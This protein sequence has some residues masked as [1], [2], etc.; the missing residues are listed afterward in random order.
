MKRKVNTFMLTGGIF[1]LFVGS[2]SLAITK[3]PDW[4]YPIIVGIFASVMSTMEFA[5]V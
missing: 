1:C 3:E 4:A 5:R 2:V